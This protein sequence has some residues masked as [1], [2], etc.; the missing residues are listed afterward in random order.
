M[1]LMPPEMR[2]QGP[3]SQTL[4]S[5]YVGAFLGIAVAAVQLWFLVTR[6]SAFEPVVPPT[7][8]T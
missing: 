6:K 7:T 4:G 1:N 3:L 5:F 2:T 8:A